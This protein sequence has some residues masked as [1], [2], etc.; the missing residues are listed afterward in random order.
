M[1]SAGTPALLGALEAAGIVLL[2][3]RV[4]PSA[5]TLVAGEPI[6]SSPSS[7]QIPRES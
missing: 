7:V 5:A 4:L 6:S 2:Q 3:D 1:R